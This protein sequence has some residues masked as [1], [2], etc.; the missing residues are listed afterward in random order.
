MVIKTNNRTGTT[1]VEMVIALGVATMSFAAIFGL[2][3]QGLRIVGD[4]RDDTRAMLV[5]ESQIE[6]LRA[7]D[8]EQFASM[9]ASTSL[10]TTQ[11]GGLGELRKAQ[12]Q[13]R[14]SKLPEKP[15]DAN[16]RAISV[17]ITWLSRAGRK[18][19]LALSTFK[20]S[21]TAGE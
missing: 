6:R 9:G 10:D 1:L 2:A 13:V 8:W 12:G 5:A 18:K 16:V 3:S 4:M 17:R 20:T 11:V 15:E 21:R 14:I 7:M 19:E